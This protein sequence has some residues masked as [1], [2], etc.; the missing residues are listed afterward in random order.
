MPEAKNRCGGV[1]RVTAEHRMILAVQQGKYALQ[2]KNRGTEVPPNEIKRKWLVSSI[3]SK[4]QKI[5]TSIGLVAE[6]RQC[7]R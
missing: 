4:R 2:L 1:H 3:F 6:E 5:V 7:C